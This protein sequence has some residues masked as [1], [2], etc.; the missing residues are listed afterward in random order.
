[1]VVVLTFLKRAGMIVL[2]SAALFALSSCSLFR[3]ALPT[4]EL[5]EDYETL[6]FQGREYQRGGTLEI[7]SNAKGDAIADI[8]KSKR[9][10]RVPGEEPE[11]YVALWDAD[12][13]LA[14]MTVYVAEGVQAPDMESSEVSSL[15]FLLPVSPGE[16]RKI[17]RIDD[18]PTLDEIVA[19]VKSPPVMVE[20]DPSAT[21]TTLDGIVYFTGHE[22]MYRSGL[23]WYYVEGQGCFLGELVYSGL[24]DGQG[25]EDMHLEGYEVGDLVS[26]YVDIKTEGTDVTDHTRPSTD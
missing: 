15:G 11:E 22:E 24:L 5:T 2:L 14:W 10:H 18:R 23:S 9:V 13:L 4:A 3:E 17:I 8:D 7:D 19:L 1:M 21:I 26:P 25:P 20:I 16:K 6:I 12:D